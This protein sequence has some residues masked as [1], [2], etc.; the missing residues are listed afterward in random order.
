[1]H[2]DTALVHHLAHLS[3]LE[4]SESESDILVNDLKKIL[5]LVNTLNHVDTRN[6]EPLIHIY[7]AK[8]IFR[9]DA[10]SITSEKNSYLNNAPTHNQD[11][12]L[13]PKVINK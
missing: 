2:V 7:D 11:Y 12:F 4:F 6:V 1:M 5:D 13:V 8:N 9:E 10:D 3:R